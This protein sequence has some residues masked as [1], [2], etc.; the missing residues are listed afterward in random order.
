MRARRRRRA[1]GGAGSSSADLSLQDVLSNGLSAVIVLAII[2]S[3]FS[4]PGRQFTRAQSRSSTEGNIVVTPADVPPVVATSERKFD[5]VWLLASGDPVRF[6]K[7][8]LSLADLSIG[9]KVYATLYGG[10]A[11]SVA[12]LHAEIPRRSRVVLRAAADADVGTPLQL[13]LR[14]YVDDREIRLP[15]VNVALKGGSSVNVLALCRSSDGIPRVT[16]GAG[17]S[18]DC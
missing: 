9:A 4:G 15:P 2:A 11:G 8:S 7:V 5:R 16:M 13:S 10:G 6:P 17:M 1:R 3:V 14:L 18:A 12:L